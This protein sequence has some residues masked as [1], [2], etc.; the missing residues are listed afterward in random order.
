M[1]KKFNYFV[2]FL[3]NVG[4]YDMTIYLNIKHF[5]GSA[6][7]HSLISELNIVYYFIGQVDLTL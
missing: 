3:F 6:W 4:R 5:D 2:Y 7:Q 1:C